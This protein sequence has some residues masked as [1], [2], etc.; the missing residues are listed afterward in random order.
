MIFVT[1]AVIVCLQISEADEGI[2]TASG[3]VWSLYQILKARRYDEISVH[4]QRHLL[5]LMAS[6][7]D[8]RKLFFPGESLICPQFITMTP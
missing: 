5:I 2:Y 3:K 1:S 8:V 7:H 4:F 6:S